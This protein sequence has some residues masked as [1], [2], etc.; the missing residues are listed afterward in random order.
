MEVIEIN[1]AS[2]CPNIGKLVKQIYYDNVGTPVRAAKVA[3]V[4]GNRIVLNV[5]P[6]Q[7]AVSLPD[8]WFDTHTVRENDYLLCGHDSIS[9]VDQVTF[10][11]CYTPVIS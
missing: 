8:I 10:N 3:S 1:E 7:V 9:V 4:S 6:N 11:G 5:Y 2:D